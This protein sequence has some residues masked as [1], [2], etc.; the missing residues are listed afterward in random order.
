M[1]PDPLLLAAPQPVPTMRSSR[2][3]A[4]SIDS[5]FLVTAVGALSITLVRLPVFLGA[6]SILDPL[7]LAVLGVSVIWGAYHQ[8][9][10]SFTSPAGLVVFG[11]ALLIVIS[12]FRGAQAGAYG[13]LESAINQSLLYL[14]FPAFGIVLVTTARSERE[15]SHRLVAIALTLPIY[16][17]TNFVMSLAGL[18]NT[19]LTGSTITVGKPATVLGFFG[20]SVVRTRLPLATSINLF[21]IA[22]AA[23][24]ASVVVLRL[25]APSTISRLTTGTVIAASLY[26]ILLGDSRGSLVIALC[27]CGL[28]VLSTRIPAWLVTTSVPLGPLIVLAAI[29]A[30][31]AFGANSTLARGSGGTGEVATATGRLV[32]WERSWEVFKQPNIHQ[33][34]GWGAGGHYTSGASQTYVSAFPYL[35]EANKVIFTHNGLLQMLFDMGLVGVG[36]FMLAIWSTWRL[37]QRHIRNNLASPA[38]ALL[39]TLLVVVLSGASEVSPTYYSQEVLLTTL[40]I[41]GAGA[42]LRH[43]SRTVIRGT[44]DRSESQ[45]INN[46][47]A[48]YADEVSN[49]GPL[50]V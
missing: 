3:S 6:K 15:R 34:Y 14:L 22:A 1:V 45:S 23:A 11:Y 43:S 36:W 24:L 8:G 18:E 7:I 12:L 35:P 40:L 47:G 4:R 42:G 38:S 26:C 19:A 29:A 9:R 48:D 46:Y 33:V 30:I 39:A 27:V 50:V 20:I 21:S 10:G 37:L 5:G 41:M 31:G 28:F 25:R 13:T 16:I 44:T 2:T 17:S 32:I 49:I